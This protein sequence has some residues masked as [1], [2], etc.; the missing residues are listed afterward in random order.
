VAKAVFGAWSEPHLV[1][2]LRIDKWRHVCV[3]DEAGQQV[4]I[5]SHSDHCG[6]VQRLL[7]TRVEAAD[8]GADGGLE[9][10]RHVEVGYVA[11]QLVVIGAPKTAMMP[12]PVNWLSVPP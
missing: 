4:F 1:D 6:C 7:R 2:K 9:G 12:S 10:G 5:K 11:P 3:I 8:A